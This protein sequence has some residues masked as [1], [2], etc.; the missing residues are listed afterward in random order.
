VN[1]SEQLLLEFPTVDV[2]VPYFETND[3]F[4]L[5]QTCYQVIEAQTQAIHAQVKRNE[6]RVVLQNAADRF[7]RKFTVALL[8]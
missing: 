7:A 5:P 3:G 2:V 6:R 1:K 8:S 4:V